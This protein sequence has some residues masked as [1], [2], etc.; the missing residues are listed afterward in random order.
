MASDSGSLHSLPA[1]SY[2]AKPFEPPSGQASGRSKPVLQPR[3]SKDAMSE[4]SSKPQTPSNADLSAPEE[5]V[6]PLS[7]SN[8]AGTVTL[9]ISYYYW[10]AA[11]FHLQ[12]VRFLTYNDTAHSLLTY[13]R[14]LSDITTH[15]SA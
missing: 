14:A 10:L 8:A 6:M 13:S 4:G 3:A 5:P 1:Y 15:S 7:G 12:G 9:Q 2:L 11:G